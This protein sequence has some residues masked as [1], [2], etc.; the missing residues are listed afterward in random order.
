[1][2]F[3]LKSLYDSHR[4]L[5]LFRLGNQ[6]KTKMLMEIAVPQTWLSFCLK[7]ISYMFRYFRNLLFYKFLISNYVKSSFNN[8]DSCL[9]IGFFPMELQEFTPKAKFKKL[10]NPI[11]HIHLSFR[12]KHI[13]FLF[14]CGEFILGKSLLA[15]LLWKERLGLAPL[16]LL[17]SPKLF[18]KSFKVEKLNL[19]CLN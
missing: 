7:S 15:S 6:L 2:S 17:N 1:M 10:R 16:I 13:I 8:V 11:R 5:R 9:R 14:F 19:E 12:L 4:N 18:S 3:F